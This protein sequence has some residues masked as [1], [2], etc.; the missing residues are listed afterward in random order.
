M[1]RLLVL[2]VVPIVWFFIISPALAVNTTLIPC[3]QSSVFQQRQASA[4]DGYYYTRPFET[5]S[6][7]LLCG[8]DGLPHLPLDRLDRTIDVVI[9]IAL[10]LYIAGFIG[11]SGRTYLQAANRSQTPEQ[12]EIFIDVSIALQALSKGLLWPLLALTEFLSGQLTAK[13]EEIPISPR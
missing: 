12:L 9:P 5:Y 10:F 1:T 13:D 7:E 11:W 2:L 4:P 3:S 6:S 8:E